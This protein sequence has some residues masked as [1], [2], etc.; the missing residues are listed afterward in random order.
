M[1]VKNPERFRAK[2]KQNIVIGAFMSVMPMQAE[3]KAIRL[4]KTVENSPLTWTDTRQMPT[5]HKVNIINYA[6][7]D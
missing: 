6:V 5:T 3:Q 7:Y 1:V 2:T 4:S